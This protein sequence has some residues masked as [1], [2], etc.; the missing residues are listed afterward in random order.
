MVG[1]VDPSGPGNWSPL[2][3]QT[4]RMSERPYLPSPT[5]WVREQV[6]RIQAQGDTEGVT[7]GDRPVVMLTMRGART[8][9]VRKVPVM[10][11]EHDGAY[12]AVGSRGGTPTDP[13]WVGNLRAHPDVELQD[14]RVTSPFRA[15]EVAGAERELWWERACAAY[16]DY[17]AY[18][19]RTERVFPL[20]VLEP[21]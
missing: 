15:R 20:F 21:R 5:R 3:W 17:A 14:G 8:G 2:R 1:P 4:K 7:V 10:R 11:I 13:L 9:A 6:E 16:P 19:T 12:A 18:A